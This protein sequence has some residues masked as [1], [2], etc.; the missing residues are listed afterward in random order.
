MVEVRGQPCRHN[1]EEIMRFVCL[2][3]MDEHAWDAL[4]QG[5]RDAMLQE[6]GAYDRMLKQNG[7]WVADQVLDNARTAKTRRYTAGK[8]VVTDGPFAETKEQLG[9]VVV[10]EAKDMNHAVE[11]MA[12]HP[13]VRRGVQLEI[14]PAGQCPASPSN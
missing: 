12:R 9:G 4:P 5:E 6:F 2:G 8:V 7:H 11:L 13:G 1:S 14:R 3:Y 10:L